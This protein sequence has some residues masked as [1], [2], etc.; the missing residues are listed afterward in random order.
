MPAIRDFFNRIRNAVLGRK[1]TPM[2]ESARNRD[3]ALSAKLNK[4][5]MAYFENPL[6]YNDYCK[7]FFSIPGNFANQY[8]Y[9]ELITMMQENGAMQEYQSYLDYVKNNPNLYYPSP[10]HGVDHGGRRIIK[11]EML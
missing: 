9:V 4:Q 5:N 6:S 3:L 7:D 10:V 11:K 1:E 2:L 8:D